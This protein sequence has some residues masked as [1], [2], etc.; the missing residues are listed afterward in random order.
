MAKVTIAI[1]RYA[2]PDALL[3]RSLGAALAQQGVE[4]EVLFL[5]QRVN[6]PFTTKLN[7]AGGLE[8]R[9]EIARFAGLS[10]ARNHALAVARHPLVMFLDADAV[11]APDWAA[12]MA[13]ALAAPD[14][15][16]AGSRIV[17]GWP[18]DPPGFTRAGA[19]LDQYSMFDLGDDTREVA[20][21]V[22]A[23]F[24]VDRARLPQ[25]MRFDEG[26]GR[27]DGRLFGGEESDFCHRARQAG[28]R[29]VYVGKAWVTHLVEPERLRLSWIMR[30]MFY[31]GYG[32]AAQGGAPAPSRSLTRDDYLWLPLFLPAYAGGWL[33]R[34]LGR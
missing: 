18:H 10:A 19:I 34:R 5:D 28:C 32:R 22:G 14:V 29:I 6:A 7:L 16:V 11:A 12:Q 2:E 25:G 30:R 20:K 26:L 13:A 31:A 1:T 3:A 27:R 33:W 8:F 4:G 24:A 17:P 21:V 15:A 9:T 23:G